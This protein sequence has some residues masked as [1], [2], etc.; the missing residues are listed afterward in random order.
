SEIRWNFGREPQYPTHRIIFF[1]KDEAFDSVFLKITFV[2]CGEEA[3]RPGLVAELRLGA[4]AAGPAGEAR[5]ARLDRLFGLLIATLQPDFG[6]VEL[7]GHAEAADWP[8]T[9]DAGWFTYL[10]GP[11]GPRGLPAPAVASSFERGVKIR[12]APGPAP[13]HQR[14][15]ADTIAAVR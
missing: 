13:D 2:L 12:A 15:A 3:S 8:N 14:D 4:G 6:H 11:E 1:N 9:P 5:T 10:V 7:P